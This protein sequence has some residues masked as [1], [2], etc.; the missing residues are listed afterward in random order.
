[1]SSQGLFITVE[2][3]EGVGKTTNI[4][5]I[6][7]WFSQHNIEYVATREPGGTP[8]AEEIRDV[9]LQPREES[10]CDTAELL[11]VFAARAQ[12]LE[13]L[14]KPNLSAGKWVLCDRFTDATYAYQGGGR[15]LSKDTIEQL[16]SLVQQ[17]LRPDAVILLDVPVEVGLAR[18]S[19]RSELDRIEKEKVSFFEAVRQAYLQRAA[20]DPHRYFVIDASLGLAEV[21]AQIDKALKQI[22][23]RHTC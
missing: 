21:Q 1:M 18:A 10:V 14:I 20:Q 12:H 13:Q 4:E 9:L 6:R 17:D 22:E 5:F 7:E 19:A 2:G 15:G 16:E 23:A 3:T 11:L 8:L